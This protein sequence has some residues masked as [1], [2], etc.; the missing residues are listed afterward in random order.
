MINLKKLDLSDQKVGQFGP[1]CAKFEKFYFI[2][3]QKVFEIETSFLEH[4][5]YMSL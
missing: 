2:I 1:K 3:S 4:G 5:L